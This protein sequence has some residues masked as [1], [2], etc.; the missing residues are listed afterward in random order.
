MRAERP[1]A[2]ATLVWVLSGTRCISVDDRGC[3]NIG[4]PTHLECDDAGFC[5][6]VQGPYP[7][8]GDAALNDC[9]AS[10]GVCGEYGCARY[11]IYGQNSCG[12]GS[13]CVSGSAKPAPVRCANDSF[14]AYPQ[15]C[16]GTPDNATCTD[17]PCNYT[18][19]CAGA[20]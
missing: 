12:S 7:D 11:S 19:L 14:C 2:L 9:T 15:V 3:E 1:M 20:G 18:E 4:A 10:G 17:L 13:C 5:V 6:R 16:C 8:A